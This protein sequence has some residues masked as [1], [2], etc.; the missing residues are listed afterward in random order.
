MD[1][2][3]FWGSRKVNRDGNFQEIK[4]ISI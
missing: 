2:V 3:Y 4:Q 1:S